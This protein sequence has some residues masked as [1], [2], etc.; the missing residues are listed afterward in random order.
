MQIPRAPFLSQTRKQGKRKPACC[1]L[2]KPFLAVFLAVAAASAPQAPPL[3]PI[4]S[5]PVTCEVETISNLLVEGGPEFVL[6]IFDSVFPYATDA[7]ADAEVPVAY[8]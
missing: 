4:F 2:S 6:P 5:A 8:E 3:P 1:Q 7:S